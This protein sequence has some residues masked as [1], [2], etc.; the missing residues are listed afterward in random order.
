MSFESLLHNF[1]NWRPRYTKE[2]RLSRCKKCGHAYERHDIFLSLFSN[3][4]FLDTNSDNA[5][6]IDVGALLI[7]TSMAADVQVFFLDSNSDRQQEMTSLDKTKMK[8]RINLLQIE[9]W[10]ST[11]K[12]NCYI[13]V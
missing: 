7:V 4:I 5:R 3:N 8:D 13:L 9:K 10:L 6:N 2:D 12:Y 11:M 1:M